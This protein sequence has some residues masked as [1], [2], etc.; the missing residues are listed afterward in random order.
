MI[1]EL[2]NSDIV[3]FLLPA[4]ILFVLG[5]SGLK[6]FRFGIVCCGFLLGYSMGSI[7]IPLFI[8]G[9]AQSGSLPVIIGIVTAIIL[10]LMAIKLYKP[11]IFILVFYVS[12]IGLESVF[13][14]SPLN[15]IVNLPVANYILIGIT[16]ALCSI[17]IASLALKFFKP[18][19]ILLC[20]W[21]GMFIA[22]IVSITEVYI[23]IGR[24]TILTL[25]ISVLTVITLVL[26]IISTIKHFNSSR[27]VIGKFFKIISITIRILLAM[28][29]SLLTLLVI[30]MM[31]EFGA[32]ETYA[33]DNLIFVGTICAL[34]LS[35]QTAARQFRL[36]RDVKI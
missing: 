28:I 12:C 22:T 1:G 35:I 11:V 36:Y 10:G 15:D 7:H 5:L 29:I 16:T 6:T 19:Y 30:K 24:A 3:V 34:I 2:L 9:A 14:G 8:G 26:G 33:A 31:I 32:A 27:N 21:F 23:Y 13:A 18:L 20:S 25:L 4:F 17:I